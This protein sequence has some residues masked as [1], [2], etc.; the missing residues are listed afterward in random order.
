M[1]KERKFI[2]GAQVN[3][4]HHCLIHHVMHLLFATFYGVEASLGLF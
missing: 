4:L 2:N 3:L 1:V